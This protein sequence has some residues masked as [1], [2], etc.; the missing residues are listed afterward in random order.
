MGVFTAFLFIVSA[1][2]V[3]VWYKNKEKLSASSNKGD[4][5][6]PL[7]PDI[8]TTS[9]SYR[10]YFPRQ[11]PIPKMFGSLLE[12]NTVK[13]S[14]ENLDSYLPNFLVKDDT[15]AIEQT[16]V[17]ERFANTGAAGYYV[18]NVDPASP[19][20]EG[21]NITELFPQPHQ[22]GVEITADSIY[23]PRESQ[24]LVNTT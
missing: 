11:I 16:P 6:E 4:L 22:S 18:Y 3:Y 17:P 19:W 20:N 7:N 5:N 23:D 13:Q 24:H 14:K 8:V 9:S 1:A 10:R 21:Q 12:N 15:V 2:V